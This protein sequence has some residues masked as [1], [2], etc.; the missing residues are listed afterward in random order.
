VPSDAVVSFDGVKM[1]ATGTVREYS[2]PPLESGRR[3]AY[4][5]RASWQEGGHTVTQT[6]RV[7]VTVGAHPAVT[8]PVTRTEAVAK[9]H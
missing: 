9:P 8:F 5:V 2:T 6:Q 7:P 4:E 1:S 3:Y